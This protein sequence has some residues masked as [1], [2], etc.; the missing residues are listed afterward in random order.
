MANSLYTAGRTLM[1][2]G[3]DWAA[4]DIDAYLVDAGYTFSESHANMVSVDAGTRVAGPIALSGK[5]VVSG[6]ADATDTTFPSVSG[7]TASAI[8]LC[9]H[10]G[11]DATDELIAYLNSATG[12][13]ITPNGGDII[14]VWDSGVNRIFRP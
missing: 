8:I 12:L 5:S 2:T 14:V 4:A 11:A 13:P 1:L 3:F 9:K 6:A 7:D 10:T